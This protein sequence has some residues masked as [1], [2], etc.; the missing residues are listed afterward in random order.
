MSAHS[1]KPRFVCHH[2]T[3]NHA[4]TGTHAANH[5][6]YAGASR[7]QHVHRGLGRAVQTDVGGTLSPGGKALGSHRVLKVSGA[8][9]HNLKN[10]T[11][12]MPRDALVV[13]TGVSGSGKSTLAFDTLF[14]EGQR[15]YVES[16]STYARQFLGR[17]HKP[18]CDA[19]EGLSPAIAIEQKGL[20][21]NPRSTVGTVTEI[22]DYLRLLFARVG[23]AR[24]YKTGETMRAH[25]PQQVADEV[26]G[27]PPG[28]R[29]SVL[30]PLVRNVV[31]DI[32]TLL[33]ELTGQGFTRVAVDGEVYDLSDLMADPGK[34]PREAAD[35]TT[36]H[37]LDVYIDRLVLKE[38][39]AP[40]LNDAIELASKLTGG[41]VKVSPVDGDDQIYTDKLICLT[42]G[43]QY[44]DPEPA[45]FSFNSPKGACPACGGLGLVQV[46]DPSR[47][48]PDPSRS[49]AQNAIAPLKAKA[50]SRLK[51]RVEAFVLAAGQSPETPFAELSPRVRHA[52]L[53]GSPEP[54]PGE[55]EPLPPFAGVIAMLSK[56]NDSEGEGDGE[57]DSEP[58]L[59]TSPAPCPTCEG[60]RLRIEARHFFVGG[61]SLPELTR[62]TLTRALD[63]VDALDLDHQRRSIAAPILREIRARLEFLA[64]VG[65]GYLTLERPAATLS[66]GEGQRIR[67]ATQIGSALS[68]VLYIL[69]EPSI[70]LHPRDHRKLLDHLHRL[71][72][73]G[74]TVVVVEHDAD[75]ISEADYVVELGPGA[76]REGGHVMAAGTLEEIRADPY[77][78][79]GAYLS[80]REEIATPHRRP[81]GFEVGKTALRLTGCTGNNLHDVDV[82]IPLGGLVCITGVSGSGKST[83]INETLFP[84]L[85]LGA[86]AVGIAAPFR[87]I[88][89]RE[90]VDRVIRV[91]QSPLGRTPRANPATFTGVFAEIRKLYAKTQ[92]ARIRG[93]GPGRF[94][95]NAK[96]GRCEVCE[97]QGVIKVEMHFLP[98]LYVTC[99]ACGG[100]RFNRETLGVKYRG[101][102]IAEMLN[103]TVEEALTV[104][105]RVPKLKAQLEGLRRVGLEY[106]R[107]GQPANTLSGGEA[108]RVK[109]ARE[110]AKPEEGH[111]LY[112]L[113][114]PTTGLHFDD[115][116]RLLDVLHQLVNT[117]HTVLVIEHN[118]DVIRCSDWL[119]DMGPEGGEG[120][121]KI[122]AAGT[123]EML[124]A[125][126]D[127]TGSHTGVALRGALATH[128]SPEPRPA[129]PV[130]G[131]R[132]RP[133]PGARR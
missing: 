28:R 22:L 50:Q 67:L 35:P 106:I 82:T 8:R 11:V 57:N 88:A 108:Q 72:D 102:N 127:E 132:T 85:R 95:F 130:S 70:G 30:A 23:Q 87:S 39:I 113:D 10:I 59:A 6:T 56:K 52:V 18:D 119:I 123:P 84:A 26:L 101:L 24:C 45:L 124:A 96:G 46:V 93:W 120:G 117:G 99:E 32:P 31:A 76:G 63:A 42:S 25:S 131:T 77:S 98:D 34:L 44:P 133:A 121:G 17:M 116:R 104:L 47:I 68:G 51:E 40:R 111:T 118:L 103:L 36:P 122:I 71:K 75:T 2:A 107:L 21:S 20:S 3:A 90:K 97:G 114:E 54:T 12:E 16:L 29:F 112:L 55:G 109:L 110:L 60:T 69:D 15:R 79:T 86:D 80:G 66:G 49:I 61:H 58:E 1:E 92:E 27:W 37:T 14:A 91:D 53:Y 33:R 89:G 38:G 7:H 64:G 73:L 65:V 126:A 48:V 5:G 105:D 43:I 100:S 74:N 125:T 9:E 129:K 19:I 41:I 94:S 128:P 81:L 4:H 115:V 78:L 62:M 83:L 13:V